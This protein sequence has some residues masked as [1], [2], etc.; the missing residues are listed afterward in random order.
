MRVSLNSGGSHRNL[1]PQVHGHTRALNSGHSPQLQM[2]FQSTRS[3][4]IWTNSS[5]DLSRSLFSSTHVSQRYLNMNSSVSGAP[6]AKQYKFAILMNSSFPNHTKYFEASEL[7]SVTLELLPSLSNSG[8]DHFVNIRYI[9]ADTP[10]TDE[11]SDQ[12]MAN[13]LS[14]WST[15]VIAFYLMM[16]IVLDQ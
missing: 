10:M 3:P 14:L 11:A 6:V 7:T 12:S 8:S 4:P 15:I 2:F 16:F 13:T 5:G 1:F 9:L